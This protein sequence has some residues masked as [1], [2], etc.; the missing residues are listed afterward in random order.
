MQVILKKDVKG[1][2]KA[3]ELLNVAD[4]FAR[5]FLLNRGLAV[6]ATSKNLTEFEAKK[7]S[8]VHHAAVAKQELLDIANALEGKT[9]LIRAKAGAGGKLFGSVTAKEIS[10]QIEAQHGQ[11]IEKKKIALDGD[12]KAFGSFQAEIRL[13]AGVSCKVFVTVAEGE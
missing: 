13:M 12:I 1:T 7:A 3:G 2:G 11:K 5:N 4:G 9:V 10:E 6:E 8:E